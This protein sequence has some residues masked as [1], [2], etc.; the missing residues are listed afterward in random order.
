M[1]LMVQCSSCSCFIYIIVSQSFNVGSTSCSSVLQLA[2]LSSP[3]SLLVTCFRGD[4]ARPS[5]CMLV[6][7]SRRVR[8]TKSQPLLAR[9]SSLCLVGLVAVGRPHRR[10]KVVEDELEVG[11]AEEVH[12]DKPLDVTSLFTLSHAPGDHFDAPC[13]LRCVAI[14]DDCL[15]GEYFIRLARCV[16]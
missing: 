16:V 8:P 11:I 5:H 14:V 15:R 6:L 9:S 4:S 1:L 3:S 10:P 2:L 12:K 7:F 13:P